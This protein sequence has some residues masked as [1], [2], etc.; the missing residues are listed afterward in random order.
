MNPA[1]T[2][3]ERIIVSCAI[4]AGVMFYL[5]KYLRGYFNDHDAVLFIL[6]FLPNLGLAFALP[7]IY[8]S[9]RVRVNKP[10]K[11]FTVSCMVTLLLMLLNEFRDRY[12]SGRVFD[13]WDIYA[14]VAGVIFALLVFHL[15]LRPT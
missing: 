11:Y 8:V 12:Q 6:G 14:S 10:I 15:T 7:F 4:L 1:K 5:S 13:L 2:K 3:K 9:H